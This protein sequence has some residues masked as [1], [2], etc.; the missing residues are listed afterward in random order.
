MTSDCQVFSVKIHHLFLKSHLP[1][2]K[3]GKNIR[4]ASELFFPGVINS[5]RLLM[6][7]YSLRTLQMHANLVKL[8]FSWFLTSFCLIIIQVPVFLLEIPAI[9]LGIVVFQNGCTFF[10]MINS[11]V[12]LRGI[13]EN[14]NITLTVDKKS[15]SISFFFQ[16]IFC[17]CR[18]PYVPLR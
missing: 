8:D 18:E 3:V 5:I 16:Q 12:L 15:S 11:I 10:T 17:N 1:K 7:W 6:M 13:R 9:T 2:M 14:V 4:H